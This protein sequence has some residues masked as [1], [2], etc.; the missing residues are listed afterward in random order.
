MSETTAKENSSII[1]SIQG[2]NLHI[3][4]EVTKNYWLNRLPPKIHDYRH[5][6]YIIYD[7]TYFHKDGCLISIMNARNQEMIAQT[8]IAR[9]NFKEVFPWFLELPVNALPLAEPDNGAL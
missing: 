2:L 9:E 6:K 5:V 8:Y 1:Y 3:S 4:G 7:A